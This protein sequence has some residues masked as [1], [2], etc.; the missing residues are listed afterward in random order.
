M[1]LLCTVLLPLILLRPA[2]ATKE[3]GLSLYSV[4]LDSPGTAESGPVHV[5]IQRSDEGIK[6][7]MVSAFGRTETAPSQLLQSIKRKA[8]INGV[9]LSGVDGFGLKCRV[10]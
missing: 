9:E 7:L 2:N 6:K 10:D 8:W 4:I 3:G 5:E 1:I